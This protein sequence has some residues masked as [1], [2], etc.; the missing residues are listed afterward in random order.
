MD[1]LSSLDESFLDLDQSGPSLAVGS[2]VGIEGKAPTVAKL[3][4]FFA[5]RIP[6]MPSFSQRF[7]P[8][9]TKFMRGKWIDATPD[10]T[11]HI[12]QRKLKSGGSIDAVVSE[13]IEIPMDLDRPLWDVT[14]ITG[15]AT[16]EWTMVIR[17]HHAIADGQGATV[18]LGQLID[19]DPGGNVRLTDAIKAMVAPRS[20]KAETD[21]G[22]RVEAIAAKLAKVAEKSMRLTGM[23]ISTLPDTVRSALMFLPQDRLDSLTGDVSAKRIWASGRYPLTEIKAAKRSLKKVTIN[24][25]VM[26]AVAVGFTD[27]LR[28]RGEDPEGRT[29]RTVMPT[30][31][32][33]DLKTNNQV[34]LLPLPVPLGDIPPMDRIREIKKETKHSKKSTLPLIGDQIRRSTEKLIPAPV[35]EAVVQMVAGKTEYMAETLVTNVPGPQFPMYLNGEEIASSKPIIPIEGQFRIIVGITS[36][37]DYLN[38]GVTGDGENAPDVDVLVAGIERGLAEIVEYASENKA[39][40]KQKQTAAALAQAKK[41]K[42]RESQSKK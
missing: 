24:D 30:S 15:Y 34:G 5:E 31:L 41:R 37:G 26:A 11:H 4:S 21:S 29:L 40:S 3:R 14:M 22:G 38:I 19:L 16:N 35:E 25:I 27:L 8:S 2:V 39:K 7:V 9:R 13:I 23:F 17:I 42:A 12:T 18:L 10:L 33:R 20:V 1:R 6:S 36:F 32:R 28:A